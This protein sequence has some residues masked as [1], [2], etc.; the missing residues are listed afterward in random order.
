MIFYQ[1]YTK[2]GSFQYGRHLSHKTATCSA[3]IICDYK[4]LCQH[5]PMIP[6]VLSTLMYAFM[7]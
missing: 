3:K 1:L 7:L 5:N 4:K 2:Y 6:V